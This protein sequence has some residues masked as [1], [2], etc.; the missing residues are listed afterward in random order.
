M[1][2]LLLLIQKVTERDG[3]RGPFGS[4]WVFMDKWWIFAHMQI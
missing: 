4:W 3:E 2:K 1:V